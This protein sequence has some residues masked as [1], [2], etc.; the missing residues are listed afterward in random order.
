MQD[1]YQKYATPFTTGLFLVSLISGLALFF[2]IGQAYFHG[3]HEWLSIV[4]IVPFVLH[5]MKNWR[6][7][8]SYFKRPPMM[9]AMVASIIA[10][11]AFA[12]PAMTSTQTGGGGNPMR[13]IAMTIEKAKL[14]V[15]APLFGHDGGSLQIALAEKGLTVASPDQTIDEIA[16]AS[17]KDGFEVLGMVVGLKK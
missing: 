15:V 5:V 11:L 14:S 6:P 7:F 9:I 16:K 8:V 12:W 2:H 4:L 17:G 3:M 1:L 13:G 10:G